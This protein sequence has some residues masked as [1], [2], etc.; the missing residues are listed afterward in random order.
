MF[1]VLLELLLQ[2]LLNYSSGHPRVFTPKET[3]LV[4]CI[5]TGGEFVY[6]RNP[7]GNKRKILRD[8]RALCKA[9]VDQIDQTDTWD[10]VQD[11]SFSGCHDVLE[12]LYGREAENKNREVDHEALEQSEKMFCGQKVAMR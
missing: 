7:G 9:M 11:A 12:V 4:A 6:K 2:G 1:N 5:R 10:R 8:D 3:Y